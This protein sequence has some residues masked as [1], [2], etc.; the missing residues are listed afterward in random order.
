VTVEAAAGATAAA[1]VGATDPSAAI[2]DGPCPVSE[3]SPARFWIPGPTAWSSRRLA[4]A[5]P[6]RVGTEALGEPVPNEAP[7]PVRERGPGA[8]GD[9]GLAVLPDRG[10]RVGYGART[11]SL[12]LQE[13]GPWRGAFSRTVCGLTPGP[14]RRGRIIDV[15]VAAGPFD[16]HASGVSLVS[17]AVLRRPRG[18]VLG[19]G[20]LVVGQSHAR[21]D[22]TGRPVGPVVPTAAEHVGRDRIGAVEQG[23]GSGFVLRGPLADLPGTGTERWISMADSGR[24]AQ[25]ARRRAR[26]SRRAPRRS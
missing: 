14:D 16:H 22:G 12:A 15:Q 3:R 20:G 13:A 17:S 19:L 26:R 2:S 7:S 21:S 18:R 5:V 6:D 9:T 23:G 10:N 1:A 25:R 11:H 4:R 8:A 24:L